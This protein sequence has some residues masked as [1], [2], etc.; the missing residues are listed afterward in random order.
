MSRKKRERARRTKLEV[1]EA[2]STGVGSASPSSSCQMELFF[3]LTSFVS[4]SE[5]G[6]EVR[7]IVRNFRNRGAELL[8]T[9]LRL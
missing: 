2:Q 5:N 8:G 3:G 1:P 9:P 7:E 6:D 4:G